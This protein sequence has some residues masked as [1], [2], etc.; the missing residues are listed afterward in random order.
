[1]GDAH[2]YLDHVD[3]LRTQLE[4]EPRAFPEL[5]ITRNKGGSIDGW[6]VEDFV[7]KGYDPHKPIAMNM[8][9]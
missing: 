7:I 1:M 5:E 3:A 6:K 2:I 8:S 9:V 4:R